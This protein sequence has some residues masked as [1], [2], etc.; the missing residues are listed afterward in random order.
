[1]SRIMSFLHIPPKLKPYLTRNFAHTEW[2]RYRRDHNREWFRAVSAIIHLDIRLIVSAVVLWIFTLAAMYHG[3]FQPYKYCV[4][5]AISLLGIITITLNTFYGRKIAHILCPILGQF[6]FIMLLVT[7]QAVLLMLTGTD[8]S[9][10]TLRDAEGASLRITGVIREIRPLDS[11]TNMIILSTDTAQYRNL[12]API[13]EDI[14]IYNNTQKQQ[15]NP[16]T[17]VNALGTLENKGT[18]AFLKGASIFPQP[19]QDLEHTRALNTRMRD[20]ARRHL[21][22]E[23]TAL[24]LGTA[25]GD[26]SAMPNTSKENYKLSGLSH[27]TAVSGANIAIIF[28]AGYRFGILVRVPRRL[29]IGMGITAVVLYS[30]IL[31]FEGSVI[32][33]I[34]MGSLGALAMLRGTGR[35]TLS[36]LATT[37]V[38]CLIAAPKLAGDLGFILSTVAT[39][40]LIALGPSLTRLLMRLLPHTLAELIAASASASLWCT[41]VILGISGK[42][43]LYTIPAN[44]LAAPLTAIT[45]FAGLAAFLSYSINF[46]AITDIA[47]ILGRIPAQGIEYIAKYFAH[48]PAN[49]LDVDV[50]PASVAFAGVTVFVGSLLIWLWDY[51]IYKRG[52]H[53]DYVRIPNTRHVTSTH[54]Q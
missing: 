40:S 18:T 17:R 21:D 37:I 30:T 45:M 43:P 13:H 3:T 53:L 8:S 29:M 4:L 50:T 9:R 31:T 32:R 16:G 47:L 38:F 39:A 36:A 27:L 20:Y 44:M 2:M 7:L 33:S 5:V 19:N 51:R 23:T 25:Y 6:M 26:D 14:R 11:H 52:L 24:L 22:A 1:M 42:I 12:R 54:R 34:L 48:A 46:T 35:N 41:P 10:T 28:M 49:P 15:L